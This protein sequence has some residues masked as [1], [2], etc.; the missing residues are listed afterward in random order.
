MRGLSTISGTKPSILRL[1]NMLQLPHTIQKYP[2]Y[3]FIIGF[4][5]KIFVVIQ[6]FSRGSVV[7]RHPPKEIY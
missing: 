5:G 2:L 3:P 7:L 4:V 6:L 1:C